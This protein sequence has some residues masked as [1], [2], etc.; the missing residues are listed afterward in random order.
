MPS[1][2]NLLTACNALSKNIATRRCLPSGGLKARCWVFQNSDFTGANTFNAN[3]SLSSFGL[4]PD[5]V[6]I[7]CTGRPKK[8]KG[9]NKLSKAEDGALTVEQALGLEVAYGTQHELDAIIEFLRADNKTVFVETN[10]GTIRQYFAEYGDGSM[11]GTEGTG[12]LVGDTNNVVAVTLKGTESTLPRF[13]EAAFV[14][15]KTQLAASR[16]YLDALV[17]GAE[18]VD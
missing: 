7:T 14:A 2:L 5:A 6:A 13:F 17:T 4:R 9:D 3:G 12:L 8:S 16:D 11:E 10:A 18:V 15:P 1:N